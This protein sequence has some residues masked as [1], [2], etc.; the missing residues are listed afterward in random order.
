M[1]I[2]RGAG[3]RIAEDE[4]FGDA[5][6]HRVDQIIENLVPGLG[7]T[8]LGREHHGVAQ[9]ATARKNR[10]LRD[11]VRVSKSSSTQCVAAFVIG[12]H[13]LV[14]VVHHASTLLRAG[15]DA[16]NGLVNG[17][18][19]DEVSVGASGQQRGLV[20]D[21]GKVGAGEARGSLSDR[22]EVD[23]IGQRLAF[24][25]NTQDGLTPLEIRGFNRDLSVEASRTQQRRVK[26]IGAV[27]CR[28]EDQIR[29]IVKTI[30]L[31]QELVESLVAFIG[32]AAI[33]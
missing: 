20:Q 6:T 5:A 11:R 31:N 22:V 19:I 12:G 14:V 3:G 27:R 8:V 16:V 2:V 24:G 4:F 13:Q 18:V 30:H 29:G 32:A 1:D 17:A 9:S 21:I 23:I 33:P 7:V 28:D 25:V 26:N 10:H 15:D